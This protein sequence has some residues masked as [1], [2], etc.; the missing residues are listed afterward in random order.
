MPK[1]G[2]VSIPNTVVTSVPVNLVSRLAVARANV[3][4]ARECLLRGQGSKL[5]GERKT[6]GTFDDKV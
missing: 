1:W 4:L 2:R 6:T 3:K 5:H